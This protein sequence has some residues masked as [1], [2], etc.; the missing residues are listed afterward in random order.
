MDTA[1]FGAKAVILH[2]HGLKFT[3]FDIDIDQ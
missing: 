3:L 2:G 1:A